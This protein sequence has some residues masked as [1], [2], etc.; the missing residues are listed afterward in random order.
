MGI[1]RNDGEYVSTID[2]G[3]SAAA[4][5]LSTDQTVSITAKL[6]D[7]SAGNTVSA[8]IVTIEAIN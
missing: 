8:Y 7:D 2:N 1:I 6:S 3:T 5:D 4:V